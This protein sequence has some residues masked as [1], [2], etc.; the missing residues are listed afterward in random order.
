MISHLHGVVHSI[1][2][3]HI[4]VDVS[5]IGYHI[6]CSR[7]LLDNCVVGQKTM[8]LTEMLVREDAHTIIGFASK[9]ERDMYRVLTGVQGVGSR[10]ALSL[11]SLGNIAD[12]IISIAKAEKNYLSRA[13][14]VGPK[15]ASRMV[16]ELQDRMKK[17]MPIRSINDRESL[18]P[19]L[20][21]PHLKD[22]HDA[23]LSLGY[24]N[25]DIKMVLSAINPSEHSTQDAIRIALQKLG[26]NI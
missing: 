24:K 18:Q 3:D 14:G 26:S 12:L 4:I 19:H 13:D 7:H 5:G 17:L 11:L 22:A 10:V 9:E 25:T 16:N 21:D 15:L 1:E 2:N 23:L 8:V 6:L 20:N